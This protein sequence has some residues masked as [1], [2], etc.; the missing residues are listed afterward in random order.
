MK[1][2]CID[3]EVSKTEL[4]LVYYHLGMHLIASKHQSEQYRQKLRKELEEVHAMLLKGE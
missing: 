1:I 2:P 3:G 4:P